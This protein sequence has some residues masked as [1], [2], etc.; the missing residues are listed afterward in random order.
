VWQAI[1]FKLSMAR[2]ISRRHE[3]FIINISILYRFHIPAQYETLQA[4]N[5]WAVSG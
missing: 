1:I 5:G 2:I 4:T 3:N